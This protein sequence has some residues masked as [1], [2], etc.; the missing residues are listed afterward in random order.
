MRRLAALLSSLLV[1]VLFAT[2]CAGSSAAPAPQGYFAEME[3]VYQTY[4]ARL[5]EIQDEFN[6]LLRSTPV[7]DVDDVRRERL[8]E[9]LAAF[10]EFE[11]GLAGLTPSSTLLGE[12]Q[13]LLERAAALNVA[14]TAD[15]HRLDT[16]TPTNV[17]S[18]SSERREV[19]RAV[20]AL[21]SKCHDL[22][23]IAESEGAGVTLACN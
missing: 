5:D 7:A 16:G 3:S 17:L 8:R 4:D 11:D 19:Y 20:D 10:V 14:Y 1:L 23:E 12:H 22:Q 21:I 15:L 6:R 9:I 13:T 2:A 18:V